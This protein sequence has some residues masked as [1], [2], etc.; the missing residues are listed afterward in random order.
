MH[1]PK[2]GDNMKLTDAKVKA[3]KPRNRP[4]KVADGR[5][6]YVEITPAGGKLWRL[7]YRIGGKEKRIALGKYPE[8]SLR[9]ARDRA[10]EARE[11]LADGIDPGEARKAKKIT[12]SGADSFETI[13]REWFARFSPTWKQSH[14]DK[15]LSRLEQK[16][17]PYIGNTP[18]P[19]VNAPTLLGVLRRI[20]A[21]GA[22]ET[23]HRTKQIAGQVFR[24]AVATGRAERDPT[25]DLK[26]ALP[27]AR[28]KRHAA[29]TDPKQVGA[30]LRAI[31][32]YGGSFVVKAAL[33]LSALTFVRPG[34]LR[35]A[36]W[37]EIDGNQWVI[38]AERM[39]MKAEH[40]VPLSKQAV[41]VLES[42]RPFT[43]E[44]VYIF[45]SARSDKRP[46]SD[47]GVRTALRVMGYTNDE[48]TPHGFRA[49][50]STLLN[51]LGWRPDVIER[52][53]AHVE[54]NKV[55]AAYH[56]A[57]YLPERVKMMQAWAD[58]LEEQKYTIPLSVVAGT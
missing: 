49:M 34:E 7:K 13:A 54:Q 9:K 32:N 10:H 15:V 56:R 36:Q 31:D 27:P 53:L 24:F 39:K 41:A 28:T 47:N 44:S 4:Y 25:A 35:A 38:P 11:Q 2:S 5:S 46:L 3:L 58:Y 51:E 26:G 14:S 40:I 17:L 37:S 18:I 21:E 45:P 43:G 20:E 12:Q 55:R 1:A 30:L 33:Q 42:I 29:I 52:Q 57:E 48:M 8:V 16:L 6:L 19:D 22:I 23:A 50:A